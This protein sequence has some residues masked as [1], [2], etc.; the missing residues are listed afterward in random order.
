M[1]VGFK[2]VNN[3]TGEVIQ[4]WGGNYGSCPDQPNSVTLP[5]GDIVCGA[6]LDQDY[7]G[8]SLVKW[9]M[10]PPPPP[11][12]NNDDVKRER[13]NRIDGGIVFKNTHFQT[14]DEDRENI[15]GA[16][17]WAVIAV[18]NGAK[19]G[20]YKWH[21][22]KEDF[23]WIAT[24]NS[25]VPMDAYDVIEFGKAAAAWKSEQIFA[26]RAIKDLPEI[27]ADFRDEKYWPQSEAVKVENENP[28][29]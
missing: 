19:V 22:G 21:G 17:T 15:A 3:K 8:H 25:L 9:E 24:D 18:M 29:V 6:M 12:L 7:Q 4:Q 20:D 14:R 11:P 5:S 23:A 28:V 26:A 10:D 13:D 16:V 2:L 1:I 27:P